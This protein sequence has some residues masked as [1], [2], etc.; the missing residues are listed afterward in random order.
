LDGCHRLSY[1]QALKARAFF[2]RSSPP[3]G[4]TA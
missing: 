2:A 1:S 3:V 4:S